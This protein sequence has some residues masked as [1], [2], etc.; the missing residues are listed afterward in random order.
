MDHMFILLG[1]VTV[2]ALL[3]REN[4][5]LFFVGRANKIE[6]RLATWALN[7]MIPVRSRVTLRTEITKFFVLQAGL[8][9]EEASTFYIVTLGKMFSNSTFFCDSSSIIFR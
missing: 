3:H 2:A 9:H 8:K 1:A 4:E 5:L 6:Y 7:Y